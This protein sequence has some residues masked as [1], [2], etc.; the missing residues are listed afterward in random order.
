[1]LIK[2]LPLSNDVKQMFERHT[3]VSRLH[4]LSGHGDTQ[5]WFS[6]TMLGEEVL[7]ILSFHRKT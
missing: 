6:L 5:T 4:E 3:I 2:I 7:T 1:M